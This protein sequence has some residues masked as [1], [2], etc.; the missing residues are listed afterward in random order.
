MKKSK[1]IKEGEECKECDSCAAS[2]PAFFQIADEE[3]AQLKGSKPVGSNDE[4]DKDESRN[5][6]VVSPA[7]R[8]SF[9]WRMKS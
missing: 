7:V 9:R 4:L 8:S 2:C 3:I 6:K 1:A 5:V